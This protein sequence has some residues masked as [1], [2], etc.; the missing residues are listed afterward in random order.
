VRGA[1]VG[2]RGQ[3]SRRFQA[4]ALVLIAIVVGLAG[5][6][7]GPASAAGPRPDPPPVKPPPPPPPPVRPA[8]PPPPVFVQP[9]PPP[10]LAV[11]PPPPGPS[12]AEV[13]AAQRAAARAKAAQQKAERLKKQRRATRLAAAK[14]AAEARRSEAARRLARARQIR[15]T[16]SP[17]RGGGVAASG[18]VREAVPFVAAATIAAL[19]ILGLALVPAYAVPWHRVSIAL[20]DHREHFAVAGGMTLLGAG[21]FIMLTFLGQ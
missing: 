16:S 17:E 7:A 2:A 18:S 10:P 3:S 8:P 6:N 11:Q 9:P 12:A 4:S 14:R 15:A 19:F 20:E 13:L 1:A 5:V 21:L